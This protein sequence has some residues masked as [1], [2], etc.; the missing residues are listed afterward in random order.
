[1]RALQESGR[2]EGLTNNELAKLSKSAKDKLRSIKKKE[3]LVVIA[4]EEDEKD[5]PSED[6][7]PIDAGRLN[8]V[9][10]TFFDEFN[11]DPTN[12]CLKR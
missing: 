5:A 3:K 12:T 8:H 10:N 1:V 11:L 7:A 4:Q 6:P 9:I 2:Y